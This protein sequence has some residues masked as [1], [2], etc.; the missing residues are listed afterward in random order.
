[1]P[2]KSFSA[3]FIWAPSCLLDRCLH[4]TVCAL[5]YF[6]FCSIQLSNRVHFC[7]HFHLLEGVLMT[8]SYPPHAPTLEVRSQRV[9]NA[10]QLGPVSHSECARTNPPAI[11]SRREASFLALAVHPPPVPPSLAAGNGRAGSSGKEQEQ[12]TTV[13]VDWKS[14]PHSP[15][16]DWRCDRADRV[17]WRH[18]PTC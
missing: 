9:C 10:A 1:M 5:R 4:L 7:Q 18:S 11:F 16:F 12:G 13:E 3:Q 15:P 14:L 8:K 6:D 17:V 2:L